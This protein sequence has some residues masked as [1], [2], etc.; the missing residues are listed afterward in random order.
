M[1]D[2]YANSQYKD[3]LLKIRALLPSLP[4][5]CAEFLRGIENDTLVRTRYAYLCDLRVFFAFL[6]TQPAFASVRDMRDLTL[7]AL[8]RVSVTDVENYMSYLSYHMDENDKDVTN[9]ARAKARKLASLR[10][11]YKYFCKKEKIAVNAPSLVDLPTIRQKAIVRLEPDEVAIL[12]DVV[13][14]GDGLT[15]R[16]QAYHQRT[17]A[18]DLAILTLFLGTG[19]RISELVGI[20]IDDINFSANEFS[21]IRKGGNQDILVFGDEARAALLGYMLQRESMTAEP[22]HEEA[23]FLSLQKKRITVRAVEKLVGKYA[24]IATPLKRISPH[25]LRSTYGTTLY[26]ETGDIYLVA[27]VLGHKDVNTTRK[28]YAAMSEDRRRLA[29]RVVKLREDAPAPKDDK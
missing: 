5:C 23:L 29:A 14:N 18:R 11:F 21:I 26:R 19:V 24:A 20:D 13:Q 15:K 12:L 27:D 17:Q 22:G 7:A 25:K 3:A 10:A 16:Q 1:A 2:T 8:E 9:G 28:H 4:P 6:L